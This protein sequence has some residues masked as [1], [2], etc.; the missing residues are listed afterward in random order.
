MSNKRPSNV[1]A[2]PTVKEAGV[3][4]AAR[5]Q[6]EYEATRERHRRMHGPPRSV[7]DL[8][9]WLAHHNPERL[10]TWLFERPEWERDALVAY[11]QKKGER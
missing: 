3:A 7:L 6:A 10:R 8:A 2:F 1:I 4:S 9:L 5:L 11:L